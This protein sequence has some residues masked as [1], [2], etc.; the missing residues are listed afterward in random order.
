MFCFSLCVAILAIVGVALVSPANA[1]A[2]VIDDFSSDTSSMYTVWTSGGGAYG[3]SG[4]QYVPTHGPAASSTT[5]TVSY[6]N[7]HVLNVGDTVGIDIV[8]LDVEAK[9]HYF[10]G[11]ALSKDT[12]SA[13]TTFVFDREYKPDEG[14][15][16]F[17]ILTAGEWYGGG[18]GLTDPIPPLANPVTLTLERISDTTLNWELAYTKADDTPG[19]YTGT[20]SSLDAGAYY[21]GITSSH[22]A[23][24]TFPD[25][26]TFATMDNLTWST[27]ASTPGDFNLDGAVDVSDLG[28]LATH[29]GTA[30]DATLSMGDA[31]GDGA[32]DVSDLGILATNYGAGT[33]ATS[34]VPEPAGLTLLMGAIAVLCLFRRR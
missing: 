6:R 26:G 24:A 12:T 3:R 28:I 5:R 16:V 19:S 27:Y 30:T 10:A 4:E 31:N 14:M 33:A 29:Y 9:G 17:Q 21:F 15:D 7:D 25:G 1:R 2:G 20:Y 32:V 34:A 23:Y 8:A 22:Y 13:G 11:I 18:S